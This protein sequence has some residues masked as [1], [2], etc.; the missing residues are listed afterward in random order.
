MAEVNE[1]DGVSSCSISNELDDKPAST[2]THE[3]VCP[4]LLTL[5]QTEK[6]DVSSS[7]LPCV[8]REIKIEMSWTSLNHWRVSRVSVC[9]DYYL[10]RL[11][12]G[13]K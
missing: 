10:D 5:E 3:D 4:Q 1:Q 2:V 7:F 6:P 12:T 9:D 11:F 13:R 8:L